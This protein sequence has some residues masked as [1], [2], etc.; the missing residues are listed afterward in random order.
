MAYVETGNYERARDV[1]RHSLSQHPND[2]ALLSQYAR[3]EYLLDNNASAASSAYAALSALPQDELAMRIYALSV[4]GLGRLNDA[5]WMSWRG[6]IAHPN[7]PL[8]HRVYARLLQKSRQLQSALVVIDESLRLDPVDADALVL[9]GSIL[10]ELGR[11]D[12][13]DASYRQALSL[14]PGN[15]EALNNMAVNR[16]R[17]GK[18][19][20][21]LTGFLGAASVDPKIGNLARRN[22][23]VVLAKILRRAT[24]LAVVLGIQVA[25]V[26]AAY[27]SG[28][29]TWALRVLSGLVA[30]ALIVHLVRMFRSVPR[31]VL[32]SVVRDRG[33]VAARLMHALLTAGLGTGVT[34]FGGAAWTIPAGVIVTI[35]GLILVRVGLLTGV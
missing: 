20:L 13:S 32:N 14:D 22:I 19:R 5:L 28:Q 29:S 31:R 2:P 18:F 34:V 26:G 12:E 24:V 17:R 16:L 35:F 30:A 21:A 1:L 10:E 8:Q 11:L 9:R 27:S 33:F 25:T 6:V 3:A 23:G 7:E 15:A 4:A